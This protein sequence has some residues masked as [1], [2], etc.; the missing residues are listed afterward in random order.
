MGIHRWNSDSSSPLGKL[1]AKQ[2]KT[3]F[4]CLHNKALHT[5]PSQLHS[6]CGDPL[7]SPVRAKLTV[8]LR[9]AIL[10]FQAL[11]L[12]PNLCY[13]LPAPPRPA[14]SS[15]IGWF[16]LQGHWCPWKACLHSLYCLCSSF[17]PL[18]HKISLLKRPLQVLPALQPSPS[19]RGRVPCYRAVV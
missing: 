18:S 4:H 17:P 1:K 6:N 14:P 8:G 19:N 3:M 12:P 16:L 7:P 2:E 13:H 9:A 15:L 5:V 10:Y 11:P